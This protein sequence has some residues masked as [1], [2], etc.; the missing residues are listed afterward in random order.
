M[1]VQEYQ[2]YKTI[3]TR[4]ISGL[5]IYFTLNLIKESKII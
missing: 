4:F 3:F 1:T 5:F 2:L